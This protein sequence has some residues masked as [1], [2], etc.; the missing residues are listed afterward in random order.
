M[1]KGK[2][3]KYVVIHCADTPND[4]DFT[5][6]DIRRWHTDPK[7]KGNGWKQVG[8]SKVIRRDG[9][10]DTLVENDN[11]GIVDGNEITNGAWGVN[12]IS[13]HVCLIGGKNKDGEPDLEM[14]PEQRHSLIGILK[15][16]IVEKQDV[17]IA[18]HYKFSEKTCPNFNVE[19]FL[20]EV[21]VAEDNIL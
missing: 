8:Y 18:G 7:P 12:A 6:E 9:T 4:K 3:L 10:V 11:N 17:K 20:R 14:T 1:A 16:K 19:E 5:G 13:Y 2:E 21:G 15:D